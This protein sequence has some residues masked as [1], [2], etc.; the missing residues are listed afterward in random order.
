[1]RSRA[2]DLVGH[3]HCRHLTAL[4]IEVANGRL[5]KPKFWDPFQ[6][7]LQERGS[8]RGVYR[9]SESERA[10]RRRHRRRRRPQ[11]LGADARGDGSGSGSD[12][13][14]GVPLRRLG[15]AHGRADTGRGAVRPGD[16]A[17]VARV[18]K[19]EGRRD[20]LPSCGAAVFT[21]PRS[22]RG[23]LPQLARA[24]SSLSDSK[25]A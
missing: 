4:D 17:L 1:M 25:S 20:S 2:S 14:G 15:R 9:A 16:M 18:S 6:E 10:R 24:S 19:I 23:S 21:H 11:G 5:E 8:R 3:L 22:A 12:R 7:I 13:P